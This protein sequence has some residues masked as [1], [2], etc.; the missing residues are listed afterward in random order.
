MRLSLF[1][2]VSVL[3]VAI[4]GPSLLPQPPRDALLEALVL[5][6]PVC[7]PQEGA[8]RR[9]TLGALLAGA[10]TW[11][12]SNPAPEPGGPP[13]LMQGLGNASL[14]I[15][16]GHPAA[17]AYFNQGLNMLH[18]F[19]H[20]EAVRAF[21]HAQALDPQCAMC[22]WGEAF[23]LGPNINAPMVESNNA[24]AWAATKAALSRLD[25]VSPIERA[26]IEAMAKRYSEAWPE[27]RAPYDLAFAEAMEQIAEAFPDNALVQVL[28]AEADMDTQP[29][30]YWQPGGAE[31][32]GRAA[33]AIARIERV[34]ARDPDNS[35]AIHLYIHLAEASNNPWRA[36]I[37]ADRLERAAPNAGHLVHMPGHIFFRVGR[38]RD[39][40]EQNIRAAK[41]DEAYIRTASPSAVYRYGYYPH[42]LHFVMASAQRGGDARTA[43]A[44]ADKLDAAVPQEIALQI[45][46]A[47]TVKAA[48]WHAR[49]QYGDADQVLAAAEPATG[50]AAITAAWRYARAEAA[51]RK[52]DLALSRSEVQS[53][54]ALAPPGRTGTIIEALA[55]TVE[56]K[57][58]MAE[59]RTGEAIAVLREAAKLQDSLPYME[60]PWIH[61]PVRRT[62]GA[63][64]LMDGQT[65]AA[66]QEFVQVLLAY[67]NDALAYWGIAEARKARGDRAGS[68]AARDLFKAAWLG[69][70]SKVT[71]AAL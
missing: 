2:A 61:Y 58:R 13:P 20:A 43:M 27:A 64:Y 3:A 41:V 62:L 14:P 15:R 53:L 42:N 52:G 48:A 22:F 55:L 10:T 8:A 40:M 37:A 36:E 71:L 38:F 9:E 18:G 60:P 34:L 44:Y 66:E 68:R 31:P 7:S 29:W 16:T 69:G 39:S 12:Q 59:G 33:N 67:P 25:G 1:A 6:A 26:L 21:R 45:P 23:A 32:I 49:A 46:M 51:L 11:A 24:D 4:T 65:G 70:R 50:S 5:D 56:G 47:Q 19:N 30:S 54:R 35:G 63:A 57:A 28:S 17:Q